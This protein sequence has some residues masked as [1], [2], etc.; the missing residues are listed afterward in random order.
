M[1]CSTGSDPV[2]GRLGIGTC[3]S[4]ASGTRRRDGVTSLLDESLPSDDVR[5]FDNAPY[6]GNSSGVRR[7]ESRSREGHQG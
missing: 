3:N 4:L 5:F 2:S 7:K 6:G 1:K